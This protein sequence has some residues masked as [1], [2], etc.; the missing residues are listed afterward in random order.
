MHIPQKKKEYA[1]I[2]EMK[3]GLVNRSIDKSSGDRLKIIQSSHNDSFVDFEEEQ[4]ERKIPLLNLYL[5][6]P[7]ST[8]D[9]MGLGE[10]ISSGSEK[11]STYL[12][13]QL[14]YG[15]RSRR[16]GGRWR[17]TI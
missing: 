10:S 12:R 5:T 14:T 8:Q 4:Q 11:T 9:G 1:K 17:I 2:L 13:S 16:D 7:N 6:D 15:F 3:I